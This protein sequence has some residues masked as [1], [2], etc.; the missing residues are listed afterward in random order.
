MCVVDRRN[1]TLDVVDC[2]TGTHAEGSMKWMCDDARNIEK[3]RG[4][5]SR[6]RR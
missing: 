5:G 3:E 1:E 4:G 2:V 6:P